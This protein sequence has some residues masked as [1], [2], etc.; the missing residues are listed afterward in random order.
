VPGAL[1]TLQKTGRTASGLLAEI[2]AGEL[3]A[4]MEKAKGAREP[5]TNRGTTRLQGDTTSPTL[6]EIGV[7]KSQS[8]RWQQMA[9]LSKGE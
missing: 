6:A 3:L 8:S 4:E 1:P 5:G 7:T 9:T 2:R